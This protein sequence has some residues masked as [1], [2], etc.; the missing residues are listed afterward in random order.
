[1]RYVVQ[2]E[3]ESIINCRNDLRYIKLFLQSGLYNYHVAED[4][5]TIRKPALEAIREIAED[6]SIRE[7]FPKKFIKQHYN[8]E[9][10]S[11]QDFYRLK[12]DLEKGIVKFDDLF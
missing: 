4:L 9:I 5:Y 10:V 12:D 11:K 7:C 8:K 1:M 2:Y 6:G 3:P